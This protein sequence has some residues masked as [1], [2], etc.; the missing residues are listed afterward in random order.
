M[1]TAEQIAELDH[2]IAMATENI[3]RADRLRMRTLAQ[4]TRRDRRSMIARREQLA[5]GYTIASRTDHG[6][7]VIAEVTF[8]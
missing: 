6:I 1:S 4:V 3:R 7:T 8:A 2:C 5:A